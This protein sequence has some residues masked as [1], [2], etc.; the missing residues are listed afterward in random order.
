LKRLTRD[1][2]ADLPAP[3]VIVLHTSP[4]SSSVLPQVI[5][6]ASSLPT[7]AAA[8]GDLLE[9][10]RIY[11]APPDR[12][13]LVRGD[14]LEVVRGPR[15]NG[16]RPAIDPLFRS[17]AAS[18]GSGVIAVV[19]TGVLDDGSAG[20]VSVSRRGGTVVVQDPE[21]AAFDEM[22]R[23]AIADDSPEA[24]L[25]IAELGAYVAR[26][27]AE[28]APP[29][30]EPTADDE[31]ETRYAALDGDAISRP[32]PPGD[33][34]PFA[35]PDCGGVLTE[36]DDEAIIRFRC[37]VGHA[38]TAESLA[39]SQDNGIER[40]LFTAL[41][42]LEERADL[43]RRIAR[44]L[45]RNDLHERATLADESAADDDRQAEVVRELLQRPA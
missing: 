30:E 14:R 20:V 10:G 44:R 36:V 5:G 8:D 34:S 35:C 40:A 4:R 39:A 38:Y 29:Q 31:L 32:H 17:A 2:P 21:D 23:N 41:R 43:S 37:R 24:V 42:A 27:A 7:Q 12:H 3:V 15:E 11:V 6:R 45:R 9:P 1:L 33:P 18:R 25:P 13:V 19:L 22:P 28:P 16:H 26:T